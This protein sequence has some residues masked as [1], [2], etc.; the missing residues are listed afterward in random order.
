MSTKLFV[1]YNSDTLPHLSRDVLTCKLQKVKRCCAVAGPSGLPEGRQVDVQ[2]ERGRHRQ[3]LGPARG[4][5]PARVRL[6]RGGEHRRAPPQPGGAHIR[7]VRLV[8]IGALSTKLSGAH[9]VVLPLEL[10]VQ[11]KHAVQELAL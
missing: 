3:D 5:L 8:G 7:W 4:Q 2:R 1:H 11:C 10:I 6:P 9:E